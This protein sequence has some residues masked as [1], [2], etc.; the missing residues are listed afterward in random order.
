MYGKA[1]TGLETSAG[2]TA[3]YPDIDFGGSVDTDVGADRLDPGT[4]GHDTVLA[5]YCSTLNGVRM[6]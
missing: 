3:T 6:G 4:R 5:R 2:Q 1:K